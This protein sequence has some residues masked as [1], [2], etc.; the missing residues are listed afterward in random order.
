[1]NYDLQ[2]YIIHTEDTILDALKGMNETATGTVFVCDFQNKLFGTVTDGDVRRYLVNGGNVNVNIMEIVN[3]APYVIHNMRDKGVDYQK[4]MQEKIIKAIPVVDSRGILIDVV[5]IMDNIRKIDPIDV[6]VV[7]MAGGMGTRLQPYTDILPKPLI[8]I[9][10][11]TITERIMD[12]FM[13]NGSSRFFMIV[14]YKKEFIKTYFHDKGNQYVIQFIDELHYCGTGGGLALLKGKIQE[15]FIMTNCDILLD[16]SYKQYVVRH[17]ECGNIIT[18]V[19]AKK[20]IQLPYGVINVD[21]NGNIIN[22]EEKPQYTFLTNTGFYIMEPKILDFIPSDTC[23][24]MTELI[25]K[26]IADGYKVGTYQIEEDKWFD[27]GQLDELE[28]MKQRFA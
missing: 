15:T 26:C 27:M 23:M 6:P 4:I 18:V 11:K 1:M 9:G 2:K 7:I 28:K 24:H 16:D 14:N 19:G 3:R 17:K 13:K 20:V 10:N 5:S 25:E 12:S 21:E 22:M 8:P